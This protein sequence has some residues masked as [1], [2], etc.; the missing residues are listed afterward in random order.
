MKIQN[1]VIYNFLFLHRPTCARQLGQTVFIIAYYDIVRN[2]N[3]ALSL[4]PQVSV[5]KKLI[6][7]TKIL[8]TRLRCQK[9]FNPHENVIREHAQRNILHEHLQILLDNTLC[10][11]QRVTSNET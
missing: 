10:R 4:Y 11:R 5:L 9:S 1:K 7:I 2:I 3:L 8:Q 6:K